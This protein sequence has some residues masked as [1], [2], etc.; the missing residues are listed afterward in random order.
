MHEEG[1]IR[2][3]GRAK[4]GRPVA[5]IQARH[6]WPKLIEDNIQIVYFFQFYV[7]HVCKIAEKVDQETFFA[8]IDLE[9]FSLANFSLSQM[10]VAIGILQNHYPERLGRIFVINAP[11]V[12]TAAWR[13]V[14]PLLD[15]RTKNKID[16]LGKNYLE[17]ISEFIDIDQIEK[18]W[19]GNHEM[20]PVPDEIVQIAIE[21][22][23]KMHEEQKRAAQEAQN[24]ARAL[25]EG[26]LSAEPPPP[27]ITPVS[28]TESTG[29]VKSATDL[30]KPAGV[31]RTVRKMVKKMLFVTEKQAQ[32]GSL[33]EELD[34]TLDTEPLKRLT[35]GG[36]LSTP[37]R[38]VKSPKAMSS[39]FELGS[40]PDLDIARDLEKDLIEV[41][42]AHDKLLAKI[43]QVEQALL[44]ERAA[45]VK[46]QKS[47][48]IQ[49]FILAVLLVIS[50]EAVFRNLAASFA[51][52]SQEL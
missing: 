31:R 2:L 6:Y 27:S 7:D 50:L 37:H 34:S 48:Q 28:R 35:T 39:S 19:G 21:N 47:H 13:M 9:G 8:I 40:D 38:L 20:F 16:I 30:K 26:V 29:E 25:E 23:R 1:A 12:F 36:S 45:L 41:K 33:G 44:K 49:I 5:M 10:K 4:D 43:E 46:T 11:F 24:K 18:P 32:A 15:E 42:V 52:Q 14:Q 17:E 3:A 51:S 22:E